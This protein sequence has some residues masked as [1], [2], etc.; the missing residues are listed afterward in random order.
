LAPGEQLV[1]Y[2]GDGPAD[3]PAEVRTVAFGRR[4]AAIADDGES[5]VIRTPTGEVSAF[6]VHRG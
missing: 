6:G 3:P 2:T 1:A 4:A 5:V